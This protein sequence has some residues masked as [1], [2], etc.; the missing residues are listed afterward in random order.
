MLTVQEQDMQNKHKQ[1]QLHSF[2]LQ[3]LVVVLLPT[4]MFHI[5]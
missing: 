3:S 1:Q 5:T 4:L 2:R